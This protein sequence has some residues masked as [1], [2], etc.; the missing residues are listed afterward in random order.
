MSKNQLSKEEAINQLYAT[1]KTKFEQDGVLQEIRCM[2]QSKMVAMMKGRNDTGPMVP[3]F[4]GATAAVGGGGD[5]G[6]G[7]GGSATGNAAVT[8]NSEQRDARMQ[9][10]NQLIMEYLHWHGFHYTAEMFATESSAENV[11]PMRECLEGVL[12]TFDNKNIPILL[13]I[14]GDLME[15]KRHE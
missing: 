7:A 2:L 11:K 8:A 12:G 13:D 9:M 15:Q 14:V 6:A 1:I 5:A 3:R 4:I 10:L